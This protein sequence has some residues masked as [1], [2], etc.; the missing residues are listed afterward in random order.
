LKVPPSERNAENVAAIDDAVGG[1]PF[2]ASLSKETRLSLVQNLTV[3]AFRKD[4]AVVLQDDR[5]DAFYVV[6]SGDVDVFISDATKPLKEWKKDVLASRVDLLKKEISSFELEERRRLLR[7]R[8]ARECAERDYM[9]I[10]ALKSAGMEY[11]H[12]ETVD[13]YIE[14]NPDVYTLDLPLPERLVGRKVATLSQGAA[15][16][17]NGLHTSINFRAATVVAA[18]D[19]VLLLKLSRED[20]Q[21]D[22]FDSKEEDSDEEEEPAL[23]C[24]F[25]PVNVAPLRRLSLKKSVGPVSVPVKAEEPT[26]PTTGRRTSL[27]SMFTPCPR[28]ATIHV[29]LQRR[30][31]RGTVSPVKK[32]ARAR[33]LDKALND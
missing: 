10:E 29:T 22:V 3:E 25:E 21:T 11:E 23:D 2:F 19:R 14:E 24:N 1:H 16:G 28:E 32:L 4:R 5:A 7:E 33:A 12:V 30:K 17:E 20:V 27:L 13:E 6:F 8:H 26:P 31:R 9:A 18:S 15:F